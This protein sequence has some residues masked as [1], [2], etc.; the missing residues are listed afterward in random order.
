M[1]N[2]DVTVL[3]TMSDADLLALPAAVLADLQD[4]VDEATALVKKRRA[5]LDNVLNARYGLPAQ[6]KRHQAGKDTGL[7]RLDDDGHTVVCESVKK[8]VWDQPALVA[9]EKEIRDGGG[10][11]SV[12]IVTKTE[13]TVREATYAAWPQAVRDAFAPA[14]TVKPGKPSFRIERPKSEA[15]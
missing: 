6:T 5:T 2:I 9:L 15:A 14:R 8:V 4:E 1:K 13:L 12:Y 11:P 3:D 10:D 7:V